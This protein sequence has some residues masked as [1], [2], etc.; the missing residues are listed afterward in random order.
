[1]S[2]CCRSIYVEERTA[3]SIGWM[4]SA[5]APSPTPARPSCWCLPRATALAVRNAGAASKTYDSAAWTTRALRALEARTW[6]W[7][8]GAARCDCRRSTRNAGMRARGRCRRRWPIVA[9]APAPVLGRSHERGL[10]SSS[11][12]S[13]LEWSSPLNGRAGAVR[14]TWVWH[15]I[16]TR[17]RMCAQPF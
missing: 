11:S 4:V 6:T 15:G 9:T 1:M 10:T 12:R 17:A 8:G 16:A 7:C 3:P 5:F 14:S 13:T 2:S